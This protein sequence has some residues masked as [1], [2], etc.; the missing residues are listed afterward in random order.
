[1]SEQCQ[2]KL[3][4]LYGRC[5]RRGTICRDGKFYCWQHDPGT[6]EQAKADRM[7]RWAEQQAEEEEYERRAHTRKLTERAGLDKLTDA[8]LEAII[9]LGGIRMMIDLAEAE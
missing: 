9:R 8:D 3:K 2:G 6:P 5:E 7:K 1:M 4:T